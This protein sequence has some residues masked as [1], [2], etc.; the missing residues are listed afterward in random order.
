MK[1]LLERRV[2]RFY[3]ITNHHKFYLS[4]I[5]FIRLSTFALRPYD[6]ISFK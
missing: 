5:S 6:L 2:G 4:N 1:S 3:Q